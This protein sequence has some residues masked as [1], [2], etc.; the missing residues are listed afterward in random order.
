MGTR[1]SRQLSRLSRSGC[2]QA[3]WKTCEHEVSVRTG[4]WVDSAKSS[5]HSAHV[6]SAASAGCGRQYFTNGVVRC[7]LVAPPDDLSDME[8]TVGY[9]KAIIEANNDFWDKQAA[10][11]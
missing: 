10:T 6:P 1:H 8:I 2:R 9:C 4:M 3:A 7:G 11:R 5:Q